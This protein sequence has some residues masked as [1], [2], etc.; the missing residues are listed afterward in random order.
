MR[1]SISGA[2]LLPEAD[3]LVRVSA[4]D[5]EVAGTEVSPA[6]G[7]AAKLARRAKGMEASGLGGGTVAGNEAERLR[8]AKDGTEFERVGGSGCVGRV[9]HLTGCAKTG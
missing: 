8:L 4:V 7:D 3:D 1:D 2:E 9:G 5:S 6:T